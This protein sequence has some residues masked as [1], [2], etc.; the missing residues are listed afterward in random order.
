V[1]EPECPLQRVLLVRRVFLRF[2]GISQ[3]TLSCIL[4][5]ERQVRLELQLHL[6]RAQLRV[7][8]LLQPLVLLLSHGH[9]FLQPV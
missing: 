4:L 7:F 3:Q 9:H 8:L 1:C 5:P 2:D 6:A